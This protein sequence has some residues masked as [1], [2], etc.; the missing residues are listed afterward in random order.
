MVQTKVNIKKQKKVV[1]YG[2]RVNEETNESLNS[3]Y[4][5][6]IKEA[7]EDTQKSKYSIDDIKQNI[8]DLKKY[9]EK[10][11]EDNDETDH[12]G[13]KLYSGNVKILLQSIFSFNE[14]NKPHD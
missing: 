8:T 12:K 11:G 9:L 10:I 1:F 7:E 6:I 4:N 5:Y 3:L 14:D 2:K 13:K